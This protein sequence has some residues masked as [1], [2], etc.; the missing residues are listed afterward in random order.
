MGEVQVL[1]VA[2]WSGVA[3]CASDKLGL[4]V[5]NSSR[6]DFPPSLVPQQSRRQLALRSCER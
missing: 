2:C 3:G 4:R 5:N 6:F 1:Q